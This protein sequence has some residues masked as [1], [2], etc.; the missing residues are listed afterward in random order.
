MRRRRFSYLLGGLL[1]SSSLPAY[2][3]SK[4]KPTVGVLSVHP[5]EEFRSRLE[6][7]RKGLSE[8][9]LVDGSSIRLAVRYAG[10][11]VDRLPDLA[12]E[13]KA[14]G[15]RMILA[16]GT[17]AVSAAQ[18]ALPDLPIVMAGSADPVMIG[19]AQSLPRPGGRITGISILGEE[20]IG[21]QIQLLK[22][23]LPAARSFT[24]FLQTA[25]PGNPAFRNAYTNISRTLDVQI[26]AVD[27][28]AVEEFPAAFDLAVQRS[29]GAHFLQDPLFDS[30]QYDIF[31]LALDRRLPTMC[32]MVT[33]ARAGALLAYAPDLLDIWRQSARFVAQIL[34]GADPATLPIEQPTGV[35]VAVN[36]RTARALGLT[37]PPS[38]L[39]RADEVIE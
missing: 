4:D 31:R 33:W 19:F 36:L 23:I 32:G 20:L 27:I 17:T 1:G 3:Q 39:V 34:R 26:H 38:I 6:A 7:L 28:R 12:R 35:Q 5:E 8:N 21:K 14:E 22:E 16:S 29:S 13:L 24:A 10:N 15:S 25:N 18:R 2:G 30:R 11:D 37:V 9:G